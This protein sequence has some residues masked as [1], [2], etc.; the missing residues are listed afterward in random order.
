M[1][2]AVILI[3][4]SVATMNTST[5]ENY[6][7]GMWVGDDNFCEKAAIDSILLFVGEPES[8]LRTCTRNGYIIIHID[9][10]PA[11][12]QGFVLN[13]SRGWAGPGTPK[14]TVCGQ[15]DFDEEQIW[16]EDGRI[17]ITTDMKTGIMRVHY[18]GELYAK[19]YK[20]MEL[21]D[22]D[23]SNSISNHGNAAGSGAVNSDADPISKLGE[24]CEPSTSVPA[25]D[26][27]MREF[28]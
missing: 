27:E 13:Y 1:V 16:T 10:E 9:G 19:L 17:N 25:T 14:Y 20:S 21:S 18:N 6:L 28:D 7:Y 8:G 23:L 2:I 3:I 24:K 12:N 22:M 15:I 11:C 4:W 5:N 26:T